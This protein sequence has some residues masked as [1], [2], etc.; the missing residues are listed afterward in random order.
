MPTNFNPVYI[1]TSKIAKNLMRIEAFEERVSSIPVNPGVLASLRETAKLYTT[2][3]SNHD[4]R[5]S[6]K[7]NR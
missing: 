5:Q 1:I 7:T 6:A 3:Y 4:R 2:H